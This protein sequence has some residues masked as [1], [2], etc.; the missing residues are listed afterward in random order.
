MI[1]TA[2]KVFKVYLT[3]LM[4][5]S[6][7]KLHAPFT[8]PQRQPLESPNISGLLEMQATCGIRVREYVCVWGFPPASAGPWD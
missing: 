6:E 3:G 5:F 8:Y 2:S 4:G 7:M 1:I